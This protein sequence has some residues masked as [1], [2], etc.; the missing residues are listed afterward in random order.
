MVYLTTRS[1][2]AGRGITERKS[3]EAINAYYVDSPLNDEEGATAVA[4]IDDML[5]DLEL[6][7]QEQLTALVEDAAEQQTLRKGMAVVT[8][9]SP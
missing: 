1:S 4:L 5:G 6:L 8:D 9:P 3:E 7:F 2:P